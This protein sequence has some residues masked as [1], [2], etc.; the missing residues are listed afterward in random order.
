[1]HRELISLVAWSRGVKKLSEKISTTHPAAIN[2]KKTGDS[3]RSIEHFKKTE[4]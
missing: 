4:R 2:D 3:N 1:M